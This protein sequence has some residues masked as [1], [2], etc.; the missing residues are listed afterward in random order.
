MRCAVFV[1]TLLAALPV[2]HGHFSFVRLALNGEWQAPTRFIRN[3]TEPFYD[4]YAPGQGDTSNYYRYNFPT[5]IV[6]FPNSMRCGRDNMAH[7]AGTETL[8]VSTK[9]TLEF[10][11]VADY[12]PW[13][14]NYV[15]WDNCPGGRGLCAP[16]DAESDYAVKIAH[17]GPTTVHLSRVPDGMDIGEYDGSGE[18]IKVKTF[19][20]ILL[21]DR[22]EKP[23][24]W[25]G[26]NDN[27]T[28][29]RFIFKLPEETPPGKYLMRMDTNWPRGNYPGSVEDVQYFPTCAQ[30]EVGSEAT[31]ELPKGFRIP[32]DVRDL[33]GM[34]WTNAMANSKTVD[35]D[36]VYALGPLWTGKELIEDKPPQ[37]A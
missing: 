25:H 15:Q 26:N 19:G 4:T 5:Y 1:S 2:A 29:K 22:P 12:P 30:I 27:G 14:P 6:N 11:S 34:M 7:A 23:V 3:K 32:E 35:K 18:W 10:V 8:K 36:Y 9:D 16:A 28:P 33:G 37:V 31:G 17:E 13:G 21:P 24:Q 20:L